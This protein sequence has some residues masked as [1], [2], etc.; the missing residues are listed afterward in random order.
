MQRQIERTQ[1]AITSAFS[2]LVFSKNYEDIRISDIV[3]AANVGRS[4]FYQ[5]YK[6]KDAVL[7]A[8]MDWVLNGLSSCTQLDH[9]TDEAGNVLEHI[10][11]HRDRGRKIILGSTGKKLE[12]A[13][14]TKILENLTADT[15]NDSWTVPPVI[16]ANQIA[17]SI[18]SVLRSWLKAEASANVDQLAQ[19]LHQSSA[20]IHRVSLINQPS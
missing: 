12:R 8:S 1:T 5:H 18:F 9:P 4:T 2:S 10:W 17:A 16:V 20:A 14:G 7:V 15:P 11:S 6:D 3:D 13:L 19:Y